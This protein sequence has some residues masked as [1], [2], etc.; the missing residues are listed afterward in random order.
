MKKW[1][2]SKT[3]WYNIV[4]IALGIVQVVSDVYIIPTEILTLVNGIGN[5]VLRFLTSTGIQVKRS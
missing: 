1:Y 5:V 2:Q 4:T 3:L